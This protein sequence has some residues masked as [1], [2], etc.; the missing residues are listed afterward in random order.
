MYVDG[1]DWLGQSTSAGIGSG[2]KR[3]LGLRVHLINPS[4][5]AFG[6][7]VITPRWL[8]VLAAATPEEFGDPILCDET[9]ESLNVE[10]IQAGDIVGIGIHTGNALRGYAVARLAKQRGASVVLGGIHSTLY[11]EEALEQ[12]G[13]DCVVRGDGDLAWGQALRDINRGTVQRIYEGGRVEAEQ[14]KVARWDLLDSSKYM[15]ASVQTVRG[16]AKHCSFCSVWRT[17]GQRP[18]QRPSDPVI[19]EIVELRRRGFRFIALA[20]DNFYP[21]SLTDIRLAERQNNVARVASLKAIRAERFEL[22]ERLAELPKGMVFFTQITMEAAED[23]EFLDAMRKARIMGAL[24]GVEAVT[25]EGLKAVFKDFNLSGESLV[26][27]LRQFQDHGVHVLG[28]FIF[29]LPTDR[30]DT[31]A[32]TQE[33]A[34]RSGIAFAQFVMLTPFCG[35]VDFER[36]EKSLGEHPPEVDGIPINRYW[37]IPPDKRP[38]MFMPHPT[39]TSDEMRGRTQG[40]WDNFYS[41]PAIW[42]R[43]ACT[44]NLRARLAF[45]FISKLYRQ[46]Y[47][48]TGIAT[49]SARRERANAWA[50][51]IAKI[52]RRLFQAKPMPDLE[53]PRRTPKAVTDNPLTVLR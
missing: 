4:D 9:L 51:R 48:S 42:K 19:E 12:T 36:W 21:V 39:M 33:L 44:P 14:F 41:L 13:A 1:M 23:P 18:R 24:V 43:S 7:A 22:M 17:D 8:F 30:Q 38:K 10:S 26:Q 29:G 3:G 32:A 31:F 45:I 37:L 46:M 53:V 50:R 52:T 28:S 5:T 11:P 6:T 2:D 35:T 49:D 27:R 34:K 40:V 25:A 16:C 47:A 15:W 20:D